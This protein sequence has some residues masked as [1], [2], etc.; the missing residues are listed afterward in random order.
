[1]T[2]MLASTRGKGVDLPLRSSRVT[3]RHAAEGLFDGFTIV[4]IKTLSNA[5]IDYD[6]IVIV[7]SNVNIN[8][9]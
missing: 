1:M 5:R 4:I 3:Q 2:D 9:F 7:L 6:M 8:K